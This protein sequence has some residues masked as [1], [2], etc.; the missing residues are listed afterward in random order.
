MQLDVRAYDL[1]EPSLDQVATVRI[2]V[3][4][5]A[6]VPPDV[7]VGFADIEYTVEIVENAP[8]GKAVKLLT[9]VNKP[10][11]L[12]PISCEIRSGNDESMELIKP[13]VSLLN[14]L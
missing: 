7:G 6:T 12:I 3:D 5:V 13:F 8:A 9:I 1:G 2:Y 4:H 11:E 14:I 10:N